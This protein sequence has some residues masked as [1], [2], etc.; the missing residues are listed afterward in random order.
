MKKEFDLILGI[1]G[2]RNTE[3]NDIFKTNWGLF[4]KSKY[5]LQS[6]P[7]YKYTYLVFNI[8]INELESL[9]DILI[10]ELDTINLNYTSSDFKAIKIYSLSEYNEFIND[11]EL[12]KLS[13]SLTQFDIDLKY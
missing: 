8:N 5:G 9:Q 2:V 11:N 6:T 10:K 1:G 4:Y 3:H 7:K 12:E 13:E